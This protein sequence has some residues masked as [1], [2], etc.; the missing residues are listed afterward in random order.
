MPASGLVPSRVVPI[1]SLIPDLCVAVVSVCLL[2]DSTTLRLMFLSRYKTWLSCLHSCHGL[3]VR[4]GGSLVAVDEPC[5][6]TSSVQAQFTSSHLKSCA[7]FSN[8][9]D[10]RPGGIRGRP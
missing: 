9:I 5:L 1:R 8:L 2:S 7:Y 3:A 4:G 10:D 6:P